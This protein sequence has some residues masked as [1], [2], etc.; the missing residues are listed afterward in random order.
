[1]STA[2]AARAH[3]RS[4]AFFVL[5]NVVIATMTAGCEAIGTIFK[6]GVW[7]GVIAVVVVI[8][9]VAFVLMKVSRS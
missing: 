2:I 6:A 9:L 7:T 1:M 4:R 5:L 3:T 8:A